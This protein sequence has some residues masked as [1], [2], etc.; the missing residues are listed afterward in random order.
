MLDHLIKGGT[1]V[2][3]T[4]APGFVADVGIAAGRISAIGQIDE[5]ATEVVHAS[6]MVVCPGFVDPHTHYDAQL[7]WDPHATPSNLH[8]VTTV[9]AGN[10]GFT[11]APLA[12]GDAAYLQRMMARVEGMPLAAL[13]TGLAW[14]WESFGDY[15]GRL[16]G[17]IG[18]NVGFL[19]GHCA[20]R[21]VVMGSD[22]VGNEA[23]D[24]QIAAMCDLLRVSIAAGGLGFSTSLAYTHDD[25][26]GNPVP[27]RFATR[28]EVLALC[29][30]VGEFEGTTLEFITDGC[31]DRFS[32]DEV[33]LMTDMSL[34]A[35]RPLNWN[36]LSVDAA[37]G[38]RV[39]HQ[40][41]ALNQA[42]EAGARVVA[43]TMPTLVGM[44]MSFGFFCALNRLPGWNEILTL[45][46]DERMEMLRD[47][48]VRAAM[49]EGARSPDAGVFS[50]LAGWDTYRVGDTFSDANAGLSGRIIRDIA[51]ERGAEPFDT[52]VDIALEDDLRTILWPHPTDDDPASWAMRA[53]L[54]D[55]EH[56]MIGG[57]DAGAHL[58]RMC[59]TPYPTEWLADTIRGRRLTTVEKA[60][61][62]MTEV[63]ARLFGYRERGRLAPGW[64]ADV[65]V[66]DPA[67]VAAEELRMVADL[68]GGTSRLYAGSLGIE[69]VYCNGVKIVEN[70]QATDALPG[71]LF[72][73][74]TDTATVGVPGASS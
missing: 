34:A 23:T 33:A 11:L 36:V 21:R 16:E 67:T 15:L 47:P 68:P 19:V 69:K 25:G 8:G 58:D 46:L 27:S 29:E 51:A 26:D 66:F 50:R 10:C 37:A 62:A 64:H 24:D 43:L 3:G 59:G 54:W 49:L 14:D 9:M 30:V 39:A 71:R 74:G 45:P 32:E 12:A 63:P 70:G 28:E 65:V 53:E 18:L 22:A 5:P 61:R 35:G 2:D 40:V 13:E 17:N 41:E 7:F 55:H 44:N 48:A 31:L 1:V 42:A 4:G 72:K 56:V 52:M 60:V 73:P 6:G 20:L 38:D 57:S